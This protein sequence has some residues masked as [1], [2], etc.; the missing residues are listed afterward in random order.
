MLGA[1]LQDEGWEG[2]ASTQ[3]P[4]ETRPRVATTITTFD[5]VF[6]PSSNDSMYQR[7]TPDI[8]PDREMLTGS[9]DSKLTTKRSLVLPRERSVRLK[10]DK[11]KHRTCLSFSKLKHTTSH[12][13]RKESHQSSY[14]GRDCCSTEHHG[15]ASLECPSST[16]NFKSNASFIS[17]LG[18]TTCYFRSLYNNNLST[19]T[20][21][22]TTTSTTMSTTNYWERKP[23]P[24]CSSCRGD[25]R[26]FSAGVGGGSRRPSAMAN[27]KV[28]QQGAFGA[29]ASRIALILAV[30][31]AGWSLER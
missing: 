19:T 12:L 7:I 9:P 1:G 3:G 28:A 11:N 8:P 30:L 20:T 18:R 22:T 31:L 5:S 27:C 24:Y 21:T 17:L 15:F 4:A 13:H 6:S 23:P 10:N 2:D 29:R 25:C 26:H 16:S 14:T